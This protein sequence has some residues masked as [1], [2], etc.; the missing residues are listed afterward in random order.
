MHGRGLLLSVA[1]RGP[2][3]YDDWA[4]VSVPMRATSSFLIR[5][6]MVG[7]LRAQKA[8]LIRIFLSRLVRAIVNADAV[9]TTTMI[10]SRAWRPE[11]R[12]TD[13]VTSSHTLDDPVHGKNARQPAS[14]D[15]STSIIPSPFSYSVICDFRQRRRTVTVVPP[16]QP[17]PVRA[18]S[19]PHRHPSPHRCCSSA[20]F[21]FIS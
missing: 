20:S 19:T 7:G 9:H 2:L 15:E 3:L 17:E 11:G 6:V 21:V 13:R 5:S 12:T 1:G 18:P 4:L 8:F 14:T 16:T 10:L